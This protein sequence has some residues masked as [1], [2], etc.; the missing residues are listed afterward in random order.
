MNAN[1]GIN[2]KGM[3]INHWNYNIDKDIF[4]LNR[5]EHKKVHNSLIFD[6]KSKCFKH[7]NKLLLTKDDHRR[8]ISKIL[9]NYSI[10][11]YPIINPNVN[12]NSY[13]RINS[14]GIFI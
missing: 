10:Y 9:N 7:N 8:A 3:E 13:S 1:K 4:I 5:R 6:E 14:S 2:L 12:C 11:E